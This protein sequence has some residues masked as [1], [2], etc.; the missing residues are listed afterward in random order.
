MTLR[1]GAIAILVAILASCSSPTSSSLS[2]KDRVGLEGAWPRLNSVRTALNAYERE[3][4]FLF[5]KREDPYGPRGT[6]AI[7]R[8]SVALNVAAKRAAALELPE[9]LE[10]EE[11]RVQ[12][13]T[14]AMRAAW[15]LYVPRLKAILAGH[16]ELSWDDGMILV[17]DVQNG[18]DHS[19][20]SALYEVSLLSCEASG[21]DWDMDVEH[22]SS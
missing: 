19:L 22:C 1:L 10:A 6:A 15:R 20:D 13:S 3:V 16:R 5:D 18:V 2:A 11:L 8:A 12:E 7:R 14:E 17:E 21:A 4:G 9:S